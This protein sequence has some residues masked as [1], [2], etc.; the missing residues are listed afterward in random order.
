VSNRGVAEGWDMMRLLSISEKGQK[1]CRCLARA[2][3]VAC[4]QQEREPGLWN[5]PSV[6]AGVTPKQGVGWAAG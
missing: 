4:C 6:R 3:P 2:A 1:G 5:N